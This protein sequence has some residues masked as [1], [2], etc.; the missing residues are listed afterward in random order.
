MDRV[1]ELFEEAKALVI[2]EGYCSGSL[3]QQHFKIGLNL[4][5]RLIDELENKGIVGPF[6]GARARKVLISN[7]IEATAGDSPEG[8][9]KL[10]HINYVRSIKDE[11]LRDSFLHTLRLKELGW[12]EA[13]RY[14]NKVNT[15]ENIILDIRLMYPEIKIPTMKETAERHGELQSYLT[16]FGK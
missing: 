3:L 11:H 8:I 5:G 16:R 13:K 14:E 12:D 6:E 4:S 2:K 15:L 7:E 9:Y 1:S 10:E